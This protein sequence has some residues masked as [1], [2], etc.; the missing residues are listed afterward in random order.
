[1]AA[2]SFSSPTGVIAN[3]GSLTEAVNAL[4]IMYHKELEDYMSKYSV[5]RELFNVQYEGPNKGATFNVVESWTGS[6]IA[7]VTPEDDDYWAGMMSNGYGKTLTVRQ[8]TY[9]LKMTWF[10]MYH[11]KY[12]EQES[13][14]VRDAARAT[15]ER[16]EFDLGAF[17]TYPT[18]TSYTDIDGYTVDISSGDG[19]AP[20]SASHTLTN[21]SSTY[22]NIVAN[23]PQL[24]Q[25]ALELAQN[26]GTQTLLDNNGTGVIREY[27]T[28]VVCNDATTFNVAQQIVKSLA[29]STAPNGNVFNPFQGIYRVLRTYF[30]D[31]TFTVG[32]PNGSL[33]FDSTKAKQ[34]MLFDSK[35]SGLYVIVTQWPE[36]IPPVIGPYNRSKTWMSSATY[37]PGLAD[38]RC[39]ALS[40]GTGAA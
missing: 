27:D 17:F 19:V 7:R 33:T 3:S 39:F 37:E 16:F 36:I 12:P 26:L 24:S 10:L 40:L 25:G 23:N 5:M 1:M 32:D 34:W 8:R 11:N 21:S 14:M 13:K 9:S 22:R 35:N 31:K 29:P 30:I 15:W 20:A 28:L 18:S 2:T 4:N 6:G 38:P